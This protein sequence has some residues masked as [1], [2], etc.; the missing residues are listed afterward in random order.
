MSI[1]EQCPCVNITCPNHGDCAKCTSRHVRLGNLNY[2]AFYTVLP[3]LQEAIAADPDS[4][5]ASI[6]RGMVD[7][8]LEGMEQLMTRHGLSEEKQAE[9]HRKVADYSDY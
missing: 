4:P 9:M 3:V 7:G 1:G 8:R 5:A 6:L 2:C